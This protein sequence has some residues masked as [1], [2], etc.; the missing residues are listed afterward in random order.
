PWQTTT[1]PASQQGQF[2]LARKPPS[3]EVAAARCSPR[4]PFQVSGRFARPPHPFLENPRLESAHF[5][6]SLTR[7]HCEHVETETLLPMQTDEERKNTTNENTPGDD[8]G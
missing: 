5:V 8:D 7:L 6:P 2:S 1:S 3:S 4:A